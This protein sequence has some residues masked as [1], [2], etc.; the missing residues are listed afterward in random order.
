MQP[1]NQTDNHQR[2]TTE[3]KEVVMTAHLF[4]A[5]Q[6]LP[7]FSQ[8]NLGFTDRCFIAACDER[9]CVWLRQCLTIQFTVRGQRECFQYHIGTGQHIAGKVLRQLLVQFSRHQ[10]NVSLRQDIG[11]QAFLHRNIFMRNIFFMGNIF[12]CQHYRF[13]YPITLHQPG[14]DF[15]EF[16]TEAT[17]FNLK[18]IAAEVFEIAVRQ[19]AA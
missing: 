8:G 5:Q 11:D 16:N 3:F 18:I 2:V 4:Y 9:R 6:R 1:F 17:Q 19:P 10:L 12:T 13:T 7:N 15:A 14:F